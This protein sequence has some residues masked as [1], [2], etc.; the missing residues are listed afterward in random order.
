MLLIPLEGEALSP[1]GRELRFDFL[2]PWAGTPPQVHDADPAAGSGQARARP[3]LT[4]PPLLRSR[5]FNFP[6]AIAAAG[7]LCPRAA[8]FKLLAAA[9]TSRF[10]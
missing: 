5:S 9:G 2:R 10:R 6:A 8:F 4:P 1:P 7:L 3:H